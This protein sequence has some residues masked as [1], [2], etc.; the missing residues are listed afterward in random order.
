MK[1][2][3]ILASLA[4]SVTIGGVYAAWLYADK[5]VDTSYATMGVSVTGVTSTLQK[6]T[7]G[8]VGSNV[9]IQIDDVDNDKQHITEFVVNQD[10]YFTVTFTANA[11]A[12]LEVLKNGI[13]LNWYIGLALT[14][15]ET[16]TPTQD[17]AVTFDDGTLQDNGTPWGARQIF[18]INEDPVQ[19]NKMIGLDE[20]P[21]DVTKEDIKNENG[22][23]VG[24]KYLKDDV[25]IESREE[26]TNGTVV[27][28]YRVEIEAVM[29]K[30][31]LT[32]MLLDTKDKHD[33]YSAIVSK[34]AFHF[35]VAEGIV[36]SVVNE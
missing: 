31:R 13:D 9:A 23:K 27:F 21:T 22:D 14:T 20:L 25:V 36:P 32:E 28:T 17:T 11:N 3:G 18:D 35:H 1:K 33:R 5:T 12:P 24:V 7:L 26:K 16:P 10:G 4:L 8:A 34:Y 19:I 29:A 6:G 15:S 2:M 30:I